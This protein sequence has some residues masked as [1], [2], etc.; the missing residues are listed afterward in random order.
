M[1]EESQ[2]DQPIAETAEERYWRA[3]QER[4]ARS[5]G[6]FVFAV[7]STGIY[8]RPSCPARRPG[9]EQVRFFPDAPV[10]E[11]A[12]FRACRRCRPGEAHDG[13]SRAELVH[14]VCRWIEAQD[15][16][17]WTL[18]DLGRETGVSPWHLHRTFK[19]VVGITPR[20][21]A[22][23]CRLKRL[24]Q[25]LR[26]E[27]DVTEALY[28]AGY[29]SSSRLY[30]RAADQLG[31][32]P[33][34]Y[35]R[36]GRNTRLGYATTSCALGRLL[37][38]ASDQ[39]VCAVSL[40]ESDAELVDA[41]RREFPEAE[42]QPEPARLGQWVDLL[43]RHLEGREP[44]LDLPLDVR[45]TAFQRRVWEALRTIPAGSTRS[46]AEIARS[47]GQPGAARA[48]GRACGA[49]PVA[50]VIPCHR[51]VREDGSLAGYRWGVERKQRLIER[52]RAAGSGDGAGGPGLTTD[53][54]E[55]DLL[56]EAGGPGRFVDTRGDRDVLD[57]EAV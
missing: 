5:D 48:V 26:E 37:V 6:V 1:T 13:D 30:E 43:L 15:G 47:L 27:K 44:C 38:A 52:E 8:C 51:A 14:R 41:L 54:S 4:D 42:I 10:A 45:A 56:P 9:R 3:V 24:K 7:R 49:N 12:G 19:A 2:C 35:R 36:G 31:M 22:D 46:Y 28:E 23:T 11:A 21:Y 20:Q 34:T 17:P 16:V 55:R 33:G 57:G 29:G 32:T 40:G 18:D 53:E 25:G 39:G 50:L